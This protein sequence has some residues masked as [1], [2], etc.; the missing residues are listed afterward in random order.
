MLGY[1][2]VNFTDS[3]SMQSLLVGNDTGTGISSIYQFIDVAFAG[4]F[5]SLEMTVL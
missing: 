1:R 4:P 3:V 2:S 5:L